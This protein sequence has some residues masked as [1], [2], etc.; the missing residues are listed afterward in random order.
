MKEN[1]IFT[2]LTRISDLEQKDFTS[3]HLAKANWSTGDYVICEVIKSSRQLQAE[4]KNGR[5]MELLPGDRIVGAL[6]VRHASLEA[7]G[8]W[9]A[10]GR[11][12]RMHLLT[13][14][15]LVGRLTSKSTF[16]PDLIEIDYIGHVM[17]KGQKCNMADYAAEVVDQD[18]SLPVILIVGT[19]MSAGKTMAA[20]VIIRQ[21][22]GMKLKIVGGKLTGGGRYR[23]IL[24]MKD[25]GAD[26]VFDFVDVGLPSSICDPEKYRLAV[27]KLLSLIAGTK[28]DVAVIEIGASPL[29]PYNGDIAVEMIEDQVGCTVLCASDPYAVVG[30]MRSW[31]VQPT[32]ISGPAVNTLGGIDLIKKL[33]E[34]EPLNLIERENLPRLR[35]ILRDRLQLN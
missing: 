10:V 24:S 29:E 32:L 21:L 4:L 2:S 12:G 25:G 31:D 14:A 22:K 6:G 8:S 13:G 20:K 3:K 35:S 16:I 18:F 15:G 19:S 28:A 33:C 26:A 23:D 27:R 9:Q 11:E 17:L 7:T 1:Y 34:I 30:V 5:M